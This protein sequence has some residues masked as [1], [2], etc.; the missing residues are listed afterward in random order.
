MVNNFPFVLRIQEMFSSLTEHVQLTF[1]VSTFQF[2]PLSF[3][4][5]GGVGGYCS[6]SGQIQQR[7]LYIPS[8]SFYFA[9]QS[10]PERNGD[11]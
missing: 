3:E 11:T 9:L 7:R 6:T 4:D 10:L 2:I 8:Y 1:K 5:S